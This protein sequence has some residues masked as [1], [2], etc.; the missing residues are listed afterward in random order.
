MA[1]L[2]ID[3]A[4]EISFGRKRL[5][6]LRR[7]VPLFQRW[8]EQH[9][10]RCRSCFSKTRYQSEQGALNAGWFARHP[11]PHCAYFCESCEGWHITTVR[12]VP[13]AESRQVG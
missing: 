5:F 7:L 2:D 12:Q 11:S 9:R 4:L 13:V 6:S 3:V 1:L 10:A 8:H